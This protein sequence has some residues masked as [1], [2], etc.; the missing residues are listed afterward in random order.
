MASY[1]E[2]K[3]V[4]SFGKTMNYA[5]NRQIILLITSTVTVS[6]DLAHS[7]LYLFVDL[8]KIFKIKRFQLNEEVTAKDKYSH[9]N[10]I[11]M[12]GEALD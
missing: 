7:N 6:S 12:L 4:V 8:R 3:R 11:Q 9:K 2:E 1:E 5:K 10:G